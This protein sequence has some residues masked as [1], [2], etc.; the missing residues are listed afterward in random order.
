MKI[1]G[2]ETLSVI[3]SDGSSV[4][5]ILTGQADVSGSDSAD[6]SGSDSVNRSTH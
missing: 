1:H 4:E 2:F 6:V 3:K 5:G